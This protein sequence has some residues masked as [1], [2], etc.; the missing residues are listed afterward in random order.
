MSTTPQGSA[1]DELQAAYH[2]QLTRLAA[3]RDAARRQARIAQARADVALA[4][5]ASLK[6]SVQHLLNAAARHLPDLPAVEAPAAQELPPGRRALP[7]ASDAPASDGRASDTRASD[8]RASDGAA[9][10][11]RAA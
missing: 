10:S 2:E 11:P 4:D 5:L 6:S 7:A 8:T 1:L 3:E 9:R